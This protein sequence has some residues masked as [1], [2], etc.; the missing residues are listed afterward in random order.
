MPQ[1]PTKGPKR[2]APTPQAAPPT[3]PPQA[4]PRPAPGRPRPPMAAPPPRAI[5]PP[6]V[7]PVLPTSTTTGDVGLGVAVSADP[8]TGT[9]TARKAGGLRDLAMDVDPDVIGVRGALQHLAKAI[10]IAFQSDF[11]ENHLESVYQAAIVRRGELYIIHR[12]YFGYRD[13]WFGDFGR[14]LRSMSL[15]LEGPDPAS[16]EGRSR[17][18]EKGP[19]TIRGLFNLIGRKLDLVS[20]F[21]NRVPAF[22]EQML[23]RLEATGIIVGWD[24]EDWEIST[25]SIGLDVRISPRARE[26]E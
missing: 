23:D 7:P 16:P 12:D 15:S 14:L 26:Q 25:T 9:V 2:P 5:A 20:E 13:T 21:E 22:V 8:G 17:I 10:N 11:G 3:P 19:S 24:R 6:G 18:L 4:A 1:P